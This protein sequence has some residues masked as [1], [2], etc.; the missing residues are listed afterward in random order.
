LN[1]K[2]VNRAARDIPAKSSG[3]YL[4]RTLGLL[5]SVVYVGESHT[6]SL[7][8]TMLRHFQKWKGPTAGPTYA[9]SKHLVAFVRTKPDKAISSQNDLI[10]ALRP[11]DNTEGKPEWWEF[12]K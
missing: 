10:V 2:T 8:R 6:G 4:I 9:R 11:R 1:W 7:R 12:W 5:G 3:V